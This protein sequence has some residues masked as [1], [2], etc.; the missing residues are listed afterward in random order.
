MENENLISVEQLCA[1]YN[2]EISFIH[3]LTEF[4]LVEIVTIE[5]IPCISKEQIK[6]L[7]RLIHLH[8]ELDINMEGIDAIHNLL[9]KVDLLQAELKELKNRLRFYEPE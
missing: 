2:V 7:E 8:Y 1:N 3:T 4:G 9:Q 6:D 5:A